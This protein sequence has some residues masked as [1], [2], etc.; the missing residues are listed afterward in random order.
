M[1]GRTYMNIILWL[2]QEFGQGL[3]GFPEEKSKESNRQ[4]LE[5]W[6]HYMINISLMR[7]LHPL[8][9]WDRSGWSTQ[10]KQDQ[11]GKG[12]ITLLCLEALMRQLICDAAGV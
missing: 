10:V 4:S 7:N 11:N 2:A 3:S 1:D 8:H 6:K 5:K 12:F 9:S